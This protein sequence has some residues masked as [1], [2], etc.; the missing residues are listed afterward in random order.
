MV[1]RRMAA[2]SGS[3]T[4]GGAWRKAM[5]IGWVGIPRVSRRRMAGGVRTAISTRTVPLAARSVA[6]SVAELPDP[7]TRTVW[8]AYGPGFRYR[9]ECSTGGRNDSDPGQVAIRGAVQAPVASTTRRA[10]SWLIDVVSVHPP[11]GAAVSP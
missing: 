9:D 2:P 7:T 4:A 1:N 6:I 10:S 3:T 8:P 5:P 11:W